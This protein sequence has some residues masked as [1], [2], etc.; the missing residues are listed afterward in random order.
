[1]ACGNECVDLDSSTKHCGTCDMAC[2][3]G[4]PC[5]DGE[6]RC[7]DGETLCDGVCVNTE[8]EPAHCGACGSACPEGESCI[9]GQCGGAVGDACT[10]TL[11][12]A[13]SI[14]QIAVYQAGKIP[15]MDQGTALDPAERDADIVAGKDAIVRVFTTTETGFSNRA[16][17]ARLSLIDGDTVERVFHKR[18]VEGPTVENSLATSFN[19]EVPGDLITPSTR[20]M[21][22][23]VECGADTGTQA[24]PRFPV[25]G[26][27][28]LAARETGVLKLEFIPVVV[29]GNTANTDPDRLELYRQ[30]ME[31][32]Y[33]VSAVEVTVGDPLQANSAVS[34]TGNGWN[35]TV[36]Q[37]M[38]RHQSDNAPNDLYYYGLM[39][40]A[41]TLQQ[42]CQGGCVAGIGYVP[43][44]AGPFNTHARVS[45]GISYGDGASA[46]TMAHEIG[47]NHGRE[48]SPCGGAAYAGPFPHE[49]ARIGWWGLYYPDTLIDPQQ[50]TDIMGYC[51]N[52]WVSDFTYQAFLERVV[53]I[54]AALSWINP[55]PVGT[56]EVIVTS[57]FGSSWGVAP[58]GAVAASGT[59]EAASVIDNAGNEIAQVTVYRSVMG[60]LNGASIMVPSAEPGWHAIVVDG[61]PPMVYGSTLV[62]AP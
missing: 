34:A 50:A 30:F 3:G 60:H 32:M 5:T 53:D 33:P 21:V 14:T 10:N 39:E 27:E 26:D 36:Q 2:Q 18:T 51:D 49:G 44:D 17:S 52:Q 22:E 56:W 7:P 37:L 57:V 62:S 24:S 20:Y 6:C 48:H 61:V 8:S 9:I 58:S 12:H 43:E 31:A 38:S 41:A 40:P 15:V 23:I 46:S 19:I 55:N 45:I 54:N 35:E 47:H 16:L 25:T 13:I 11:A 28:A 29:N 4:F 1:T 59:A 42:Y